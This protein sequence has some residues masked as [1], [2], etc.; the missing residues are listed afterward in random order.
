MKMKWLKMKLP[1]HFSVYV[2]K[3]KWPKCELIKGQIA[4]NVCVRKRQE[5]RPAGTI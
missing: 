4:K 2:T 5:R 1:N 3:E